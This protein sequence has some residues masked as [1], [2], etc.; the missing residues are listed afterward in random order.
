VAEVEHEILIERDPDE[1]WKVV[2]DFGGVG[3]WMPGIEGVTVDGDRRTIATFGINVVE[4]LR[5]R[6]DATR[7]LSYS[8]VELPMPLESHLATVTVHPADGGSRVTY[9]VAVVPDEALALFDDVYKNALTE[10]KARVEQ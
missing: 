8:V 2:G 9:S 10:L 7:T 4:Q 5:V 1:V 6:D 3:D